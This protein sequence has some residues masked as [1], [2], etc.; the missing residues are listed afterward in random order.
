[1]VKWL[2][3]PMCDQHHFVRPFSMT[4]V[5]N[6]MVSGPRIRHSIIGLKSYESN[7]TFWR[8]LSSSVTIGHVTLLCKAAGLRQR[9]HEVNINLTID[10][11]KVR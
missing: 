2:D 4:G 5:Y 11:G 10:H 1:M 3:G 9:S 7:N 8:T 6:G